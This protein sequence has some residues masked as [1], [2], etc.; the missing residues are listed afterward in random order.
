MTSFTFMHAADLHLDSP[1]QGLDPDAPVERIRGATRLALI[2][3]VD[4]AL[5]QGVAFV[6]VAGDLYD[7]NWRDWRTGHFLVE[8]LGRLKRAGIAVIAISGNHDAEQTLTKQLPFPGVMLPSNEAA[9]HRIPSLKVAVHGQSYATREVLH[10]MA[11]GYPPPV[12]DYFN[13]GLLH[14]ACGSADHDDYA[15][16]SPADLKA[17]NYQYWALGHVH[18]RAEVSREPWIVF[19][20]VLQGRHVKEQGAK[21]VTMVAVDDGKVVSVVHEPVDVLRW[22][23]V[24]VDV[25]GLPNPAAVYA[26][27]S[28]ALALAFDAA[29]GRMLAVRVIVRGATPAHAALLRDPGGTREAVRAAA[30][31]VADRSSLWIESVRLRTWPMGAA[32]GWAGSGAPATLLDAMKRSMDAPPGLQAAVAD[33]LK[34]TG[35]TLP[36]DHP[37]WAVAEGRIPD[38]LAERVRALLLGELGER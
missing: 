23:Q 27:A 21:G 3:L 16:C 7:G 34:R 26:A 31:E 4:L 29:Q 28:S 13:I 2:N 6:V 9:T 38:D 11:L 20:G 24:D 17:M 35:G 15:P 14:T 22:A 19:S 10:N 12:D 8:Q 25:D 36:K 1:L 33:L 30:L 32:A 37:A 18:V 5:E